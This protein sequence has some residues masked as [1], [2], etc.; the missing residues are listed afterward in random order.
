MRDSVAF[1]NVSLI[2]DPVAFLTHRTRVKRSHIIFLVIPS[3]RNDREL[4]LGVRLIVFKLVGINWN[5]RGVE[6][7][8]GNLCAEEV[9]LKLVEKGVGYDL[10]LEITSE[11]I[12]NFTSSSQ[13]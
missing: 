5:D 10:S 12:F 1:K 8:S 4:V 9:L 3:H 13:V 6:A 2:V 11:V 7:N